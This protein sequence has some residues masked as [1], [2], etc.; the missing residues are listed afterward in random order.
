MRRLALIGLVA[1][2][3]CTQSKASLDDDQPLRVLLV[4]TD[5]ARAEVTAE[6]SW[7]AAHADLLV[8]GDLMEDAMNEALA[9]S[10]NSFRVRIADT[11]TLS[12]SE[13]DLRRESDGDP[14]TDPGSD[15]LLWVDSRLQ[16]ASSRLARLRR[17]ARAD[18]VVVIMAFITA[19]VGGKAST[20]EPSGDAYVDS[21]AALVRRDQAISY[22]AFA[23]ELGHLLGA[24]HDPFMEPTVFT[25]VGV[26]PSTGLGVGPTDAMAY[27]WVDTTG[28]LYSIMGSWDACDDVGVSCDGVPRFSNPHV[29][30]YGHPFGS[31][32]PRYQY[33][34]NA[35][36]I[37]HWFPFVS[38]YYEYLVGTET[39][40]SH[41]YPASCGVM[42]GT[43]IDGNSC[44]SV[45][46]DSDSPSTW[47]QRCSEVRG[48]AIFEGLG[49][50]DLSAMWLLQKVEGA[51]VFDGT[52]ATS[53]SALSRLTDVEALRLVDNDQLLSMQKPDLLVRGELMATDNAA[54][55]ALDDVRTPGAVDS[56]SL[57]DNPQLRSIAGL[58]NVTVAQGL[59]VERN[60]LLVDLTGLS[61]LRT[62]TNDL[63]LDGAS[64]LTSLSSLSYLET[65]GGAFT[66]T[67]NP[68]LTDCQLPRLV[69]TGSYQ[70]SGNTFACFRSFPMTPGPS[71]SPTP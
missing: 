19:D 21:A 48:D 58:Q 35:C 50:T 70:L 47:D 13:A 5:E 41:T 16:D 18:V 4:Y 64:H 46:V 9:G 11:A 71:S 40:G 10:G 44:S 43:D 52:A 63:T 7:S 1:L 36:A 32:R 23:H 31:S 27:G 67:N 55:F 24:Y 28:G 29:E 62:V 26:G 68:S 30:V 33:S 17:G 14:A 59:R 60:P 57:V 61:S 2:C 37:D 34:F 69:S 54:L 8:D 49:V 25:T 3:A 12:R 45:W 51:L 6:T 65:V 20:P 56:V 22:F 53:L 15:M 38:N 39:Y 66:L 42:R